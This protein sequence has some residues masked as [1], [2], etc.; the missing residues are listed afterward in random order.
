VVFGPGDLRR[1]HGADE[2]VTVDELEEYCCTLV[3]TLL[4][5]FPS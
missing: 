2:Y 1:A 5:L 3:A 4:D